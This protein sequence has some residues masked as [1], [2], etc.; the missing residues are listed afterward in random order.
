MPVIC[1]ILARFV[2]GEIDSAQCAQR[3]KET[4]D[5]R[6]PWHSVFTIQRPS[7]RLCFYLQAVETLAAAGCDMVILS[8]ANTV[9]IKDIVDHHGLSQ[10]F[11]AV[12]NSISTHPTTGLL[13]RSCQCQESSCP[14]NAM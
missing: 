12:C 10:H 1:Q 14:V 13:T 4:R 8:D 6:F 3:F 9:F 11:L 2:N 7:N 5:C